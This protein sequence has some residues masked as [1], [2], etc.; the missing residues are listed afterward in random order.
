MQ[1]SLFV[2]FVAALVVLS[3][4]AQQISPTPPARQPEGP[5][6]L[7]DE[8]ADGSEQLAATQ[9][10]KKFAS[11]SELAAFLKERQGHRCPRCHDGD[12]RSSNGSAVGDEI[13]GWLSGIRWRGRL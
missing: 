2:L 1:T 11:V 6:I 13:G 4:C 12:G 10:L 7:P 8:T 9:D 5:V 3:A